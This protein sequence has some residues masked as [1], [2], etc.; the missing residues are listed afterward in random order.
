MLFG[1]DDGINFQDLLMLSVFVM[2]T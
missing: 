1:C 2:N